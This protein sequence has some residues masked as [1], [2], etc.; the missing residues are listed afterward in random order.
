MSRYELGPRLKPTE[1]Q[2]PS[3]LVREYVLVVKLYFKRPFR[4]LKAY[5]PITLTE[6]E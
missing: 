6:R 2:D 5:T 3:V 1:R 4:D